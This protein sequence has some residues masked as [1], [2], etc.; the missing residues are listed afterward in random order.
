MALI[1]T[2]PPTVAAYAKPRELGAFYIDVDRFARMIRGELRAPPSRLEIHPRPEDV[3]SVVWT[4]PVYGRCVTVD[5]ECG[6][7]QSDMKWTAKFSGRARLRTIGLGNPDWALSH[8]WGEY[9]A[10]ATA[11][12]TLMRDSSVLKVFQNGPYYDIPVLKRYGFGVNNIFDTRDAR[13][14]TSATSRLGLKF[15]ATLYDDCPPWAEE[16]G[17]DGDKVALTDN[18]DQLMTYNCYDCVETAR[19]AEG[20]WAEEEWQTPRVQRLYETFHA[21]SWIAAKMH[22]T[23]LYV[24]AEAR[25]RLADELEAEYGVREAL[26]LKAVGIPAFTCSPNSIRSLVFKRHETEEI[27]R[28]S[29]PDPIDPKM[30][31]S[32]TN[33]KVDQGSLL[34]LYVDPGTPDE[35]RN[36]INLYWQA[37]GVWKARST[38]VTS[39]LVSQA[40][41][42]DGRIRAGWNSCGTDTGRFSCS[43]PNL[44]TLSKAK[45]EGAHLSGTLP[46]MRQM[47]RA[48]PGYVL[49]EADFS[50]LE[51]RV[52]AAVSGDETL[53]LALQTG[54]VY[55][56]DAKEIFRLPAHLTK[57]KC[58]GK[59]AK[60]L[61]HVAPAARQ[62]AKTVH[63]GYQ[64]G[65]GTDVLFRQAIEVD[66]TL[67]YGAVQLVHNGMK[68][69][70]SQTVAYWYQEQERVRDTG[71]SESR[72]LNQRRVYPREPPITEVANYPIQST[73]A[74]IMN[75]AFIAIDAQLPKASRDTSVV[76]QFHDAGLW[77]V[78]DTDRDRRAVEN[79]VREC[80]ERPHVING[81]SRSF[82]TEVKWGYSW[83]QC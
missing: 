70:Y 46:N 10:V 57:C 45:E 76:G 52:M 30:W 60:P 47:Y 54:D 12:S 14:A 34:M 33:I 61:E 38:F 13:K 63:L 50:Q 67:K 31:S 36:I 18:W 79:L 39:E 71:Y 44:M 35:L 17:E 69:R 43:E 15:M 19:V 78:P 22:T 51:L 9:P 73:A 58:E 77:E 28:F 74:D 25:Q 59:C 48:K 62:L 82:P 75:L 1:S 66:R 80:M 37:E 68:K 20:I 83:S 40:I 56:A 27:R 21:L 55:L 65:A 2:W 4:H 8:R 16:E 42:L 26:L 32:E 24:D 3:E 11:I 29:L 64:Y 7:E 23:G 5:I 72:I 81:K 49:M 6:P 41:G 53:E